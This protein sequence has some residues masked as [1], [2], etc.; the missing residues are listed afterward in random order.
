[1]AGSTIIRHVWFYHFRFIEL[2]KNKMRILD[3]DVVFP[4]IHGTMGEDGTLQGTLELLGIPYVGC[5]VLASS[6]GMDK[7]ITKLVAE[8]EGIPVVRYIVATEEQF[9]IFSTVKEKFGSPIFVKPASLGSS[10]GVSKVN[11]EEEFAQALKEVFELDRKALIEE[12]IVGREVECSI[13]TNDGLKISGVGEVSTT[14]DFYSFEAKYLDENGVKITVPAELSEEIV[15][16]IQEYSSRLA[17]VCGLR[18]LTRIDYFYRESDGSILLNEM[19]TLPGF[20]AMSMYPRLWACEGYSAVRLIN[21]LIDD[22]LD[23]P[24]QKI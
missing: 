18:G 11:N 14:H 23:K 9:P 17:I 4:I 6:I 16:K 22:A 12:A 3:V 5:G 8:H 19:N 15:K 24:F 10:V 7:S 21:A 2:D 20:T 13:L 1:M